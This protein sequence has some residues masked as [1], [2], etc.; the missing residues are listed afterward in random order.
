[1]YP[2]LT[3]ANQGATRNQPVSDDLANALA[4]LGPMGIRA[5]VFSGGQD[6]FGLGYRRTGSTRHDKGQAADVRFYKGDRQL[7]WANPD[8]LPAF[9]EIVQRGKQAGLTGFGAGPG[10]MPEGSM[11]IGYGKPGVWG[12]GGKGVNAP[13]WLRT[14]Y[15]TP[16][17]NTG[18]E[19]DPIK[20]LINQGHSHFDDDIDRTV[21]NIGPAQPQGMSMGTSQA[22]QGGLGGFLNTNRSALMGLG[23]DLLR[24]GL[25][26]RRGFT[27]RNT[28]IGQ[29]SDTKRREDA[30]KKQQIA[31]QRNMTAEYLAEK[32]PDLYQAIVSGRMPLD[33]AWGEY[34]KGPAKP[35]YS[36]YKVV[37]GRLINLAGTEGPMDVT[38]GGGG[39]DLFGGIPEEQFKGE[40]GL[41]KEYTPQLK[42]LRAAAQGYDKVRKAASGNTAADDL[43]LIF[44]YM[45]TLDPTSTV[46][47]GEFANAQNAGGV[48]DQIINIYNNV[49]TGQR[50]TPTQR[51]NFVESAGRQYDAYQE[52]WGRLNEQ[53]GQLADQYGFDRSRIIAPIKTFEPFDAGGFQKPTMSDQDIAES[54]QNAID[55]IQAGKDPAFVIQKL[56]ESGVPV[57]VELEQSIMYRGQ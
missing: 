12:A 2:Y 44:G 9:T 47:E 26:T 19:M 3:Y 46:R 43:A 39:T 34:L 13:D 38:P 7:N 1:M 22:Q 51:A 45:K 54:Q 31:E 33:V 37:D 10:Y 49:R 14:A 27:G 21:N 52:Q 29:L 41:R 36:N 4:F 17:S 40:S 48:G 53:Y 16:I 23:I 30:A 6:P 18:N 56:K 32:R 57:P 5:E 25:D 50:L 35:D 55:A 15:N 28:M 20:A 8:D 11:H 24:R 42:P